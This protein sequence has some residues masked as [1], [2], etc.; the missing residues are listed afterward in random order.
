MFTLVFSFYLKIPN[1]FS[2]ARGRYQNRERE[3]ENDCIFPE[4]V[5]G[6][7][8]KGTGG[9]MAMNGRRASLEGM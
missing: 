5:G 9:G 3:L 1:Y 7:R 4:E 8:V 2:H 6:I